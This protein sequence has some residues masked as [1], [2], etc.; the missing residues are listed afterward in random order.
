M[1]RGASG[2]SGGKRIDRVGVGVGR[3]QD[4]R[5]DFRGEGYRRGGV[6]GME[7]EDE[8]KMEE[9]TRE[10]SRSGAGT[11]TVR[12]TNERQPESVG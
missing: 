5:R 4:T 3:L 11:Y 7:I 12:H 10:F 9:R 6:W 2:S 8:E 1:S